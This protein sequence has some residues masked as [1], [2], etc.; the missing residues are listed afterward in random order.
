M[1]TALD[2]ITLE[3]AKAHL[4][5]DFPAH[6][7][8]ITRLIH[9]AVALIEKRTQHMLYEREETRRIKSGYE[10]YDYPA[11][12][13]TLGDGLDYQAEEH[14]GYTRLYFGSTRPEV[15]T[16]TLGYA[17]KEQ[18]PEPLISACYKLLTYLFEHRDTY[19]AELPSDVY[20]MIRPYQRYATI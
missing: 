18:V 5:V 13:D 15:V 8:L 11:T 4:A 10:L 20:L 12:V 2:L 17:E 9:T 3:E 1:A 14:A 6:D 7:M 16:L 19:Q